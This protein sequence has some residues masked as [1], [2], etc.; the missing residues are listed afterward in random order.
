[1]SNTQTHLSTFDEAARRLHTRWEA[2]AEYWRDG[3]QR[4]FAQHHYAPLQQEHGRMA[5]KA[6]ALAAAL[7]AAQ[8]S[9]K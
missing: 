7:Q 5:A 6:T 9:V 4:E 8:R 3:V 2:A 1:M